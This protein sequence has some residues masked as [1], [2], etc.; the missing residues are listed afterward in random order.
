MTRGSA[1]FRVRNGIKTL[2][3]VL[4]KYVK[5]YG[6]YYSQDYLVEMS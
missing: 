2:R 5:L 4:S 3:S 1:L 6:F